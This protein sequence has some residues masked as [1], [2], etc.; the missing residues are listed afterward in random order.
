M[1]KEERN[2]HWPFFSFFFYL[3]KNHGIKLLLSSIV[4]NFLVYVE[5]SVGP[6]I[7]QLEKIL[8]ALNADVFLF[9]NRAK[10]TLY[11]RALLYK[12]FDNVKKPV[13]LIPHAPHLRDP[14]SEFCPFDEKGNPLPDYCDFW[15][16]LRFG[17]PWVQLPERKKQF[18]IVGYPGC[19]SEWLRH[20]LQK[21]PKDIAGIE[22]KTIAGK[23]KKCL[24]IIR[25]YLPIGQRRPSSL[26]PFIVDYNDFSKPLKAL[27]KAINICEDE[28]ELIIKPHPSNN[29]YALVEDF[30]KT[31]IDNW[32]ISYEPIYALLKEVDIVVSLFSTIL[33]VPAIAGIPT[34]IV[35]SKLQQH[36][37]RTWDLLREMYT[38]MRFYV[39]DVEQLPKIFCD[40]LAEIKNNGNEKVVSHDI[41]HLR[42]YFPD[43]AIAHS[44]ERINV[45]STVAVK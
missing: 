30:R 1:Y 4:S 3:L 14:I 42:Y 10:T 12:Y 29:Y 15:I 21:D 20:L 8:P 27:T 31:V 38:G 37:H 40:I 32:S 22:N 45:I 41:N 23:K 7:V 43:G 24:F 39:E 2:V 5:R 35:N 17:T 18:S 6:R 16:P 26:D 9:D 34:I 33:L 36:V 19:D 28:I 44:L 13:I 25:R 11:G